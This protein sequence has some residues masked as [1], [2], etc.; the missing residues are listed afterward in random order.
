MEAYLARETF[1][2]PR[3]RH[4]T[5]FGAP[6]GAT[7]MS[8]SESRWLWCRLGLVSGARCNRA[9][10]ARAPSPYMDHPARVHDVEAICRSH[11]SHS[12][13]HIPGSRC[14]IVQ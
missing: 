8:Q 13:G 12:M 14:H 10:M 1:S 6:F 9:F 4:P 5:W 3:P 11:F 7:S 2:F